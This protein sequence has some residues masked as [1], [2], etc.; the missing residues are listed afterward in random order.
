MKFTRLVCVSWVKGSSSWVRRTAA[1]QVES[2]SEAKR[3]LMV[4]GKVDVGA[5][6]ERLFGERK[7]R[8]LHTMQT[9]KGDKASP[10]KMQT[11]HKKVSGLKSNPGTLLLRGSSSKQCRPMT[12][13][14]NHFTEEEKHSKPEPRFFF[15]SQMLAAKQ[16]VRLP[17][18]ISL[19]LTASANFWGLRHWPCRDTSLWFNELNDP[20]FVCLRV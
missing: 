13:E 19:L 10:E 14:C 1:T 2:K 6:F 9:L 8:T 20:I 11:P 15:L 7:G 5:F 4:T 3:S 18:N 17:N 16:S 12:C